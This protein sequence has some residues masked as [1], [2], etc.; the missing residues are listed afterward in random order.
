MQKFF[1]HYFSKCYA[2][3]LVL[4]VL[5]IIELIFILI[6]NGKFLRL[7]RTYNKVIKT[8]EKGDVFD[9][10]LESLQRMKR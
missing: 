4:S 7:N 5:S 2:D 10:F 6:I 1:R 9:I 3:Y 8:L